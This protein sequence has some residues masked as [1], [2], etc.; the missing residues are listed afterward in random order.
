[1]KHLLA[2]VAVLAVVVIASGMPV[3]ADS[4]L[5][6]VGIGISF[7]PSQTPLLLGIEVGV[8]NRFGW[9]HISLMLSPSGGTLLHTAFLLPIGTDGPTGTTCLTVAVAAL[10]H[11]GA[12]N[13][14]GKTELCF[15]GGLNQRYA[16]KGRLMLAGG[17]EFLYPSFLPAPLFLLHGGWRIP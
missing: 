17:I 11:P 2:A 16:G 4:I 14:P 5:D 6:H 12:G 15:G 9:T 3:Q 7:S 8:S 13:A 1:M 10:Q